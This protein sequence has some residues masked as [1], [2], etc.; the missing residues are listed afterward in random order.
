MKALYSDSKYRF[1]HGKAPRGR[2]RWAFSFDGKDGID[3]VFFAELSVFG[4]AKKSAAGEA[5]ARGASYF[6]LES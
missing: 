6:D 3:D 4:D 2:G 5:K 1:A